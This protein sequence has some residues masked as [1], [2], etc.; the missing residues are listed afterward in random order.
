MVS[1][2]ESTLKKSKKDEKAI[3]KIPKSKIAKQ[4][5]SSRTI[6]RTPKKIPRSKVPANTFKSPTKS[7]EGKLGVDK[8]N[9]ILGLTKINGV[10]HVQV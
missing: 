2:Y 3:V 5:K 6:T 1:T 7:V 9:K 4:S 10:V 8:I